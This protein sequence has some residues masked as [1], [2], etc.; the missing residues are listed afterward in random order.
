MHRVFGFRSIGFE[1]V[2]LRFHLHVHS[3]YIS[4]GNTTPKPALLTKALRKCAG[5]G[6][7]EG[8]SLQVLSKSWAQRHLLNC[9]ALGFL[10]MTLA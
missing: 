4:I 7:D 10:R 9:S 8:K 6:V 1:F 5:S 3:L 2:G